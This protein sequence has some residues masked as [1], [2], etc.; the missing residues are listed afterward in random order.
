MQEGAGAAAEIGHEAG[1]RLRLQH[2]P[3]LVPQQCLQLVRRDLLAPY[4][5]H[6]HLHENWNNSIKE[7]HH[8]YCVLAGPRGLFA[9]VQ[10]TSQCAFQP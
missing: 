2:L 8:V 9:C 7:L 4:V 5:G 1:G 3:R 6:H 10:T